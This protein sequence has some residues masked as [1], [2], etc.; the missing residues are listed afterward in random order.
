[1]LSGFDDAPSLF[2]EDEV[3]PF[4][5]QN[6]GIQEIQEPYNEQPNPNQNVHQ[7]EEPEEEINLRSLESTV[8][9]DLEN[10]VTENNENSLEAELTEEESLQLKNSETRKLSRQIQ[11]A[12]LQTI[13]KKEISYAGSIYNLL[14][15]TTPIGILFV[16]FLFKSCGLFGGFIFLLISAF[17]SIISLKFLHSSKNKKQL[18]T[19]N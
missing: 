8:H 16:P 4:E 14:T 10:T 11:K 2:D 3:N 18:K 12:N 5:R 13:T 19:K 1:M 9:F 15:S 17:I 6:F 7:E